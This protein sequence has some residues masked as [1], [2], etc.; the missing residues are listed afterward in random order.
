MIQ[1]I[2]QN[3]TGIKI[4]PIIH[5]AKVVTELWIHSSKS[6]IVRKNGLIEVISRCIALNNTDVRHKL[7]LVSKYI[8][9][10]ELSKDDYSALYCALVN[11]SQKVLNE[12]VKISDIGEISDEE[13]Q[14]NIKI[15][16][17]TI[18]LAIEEHSERIKRMEK[19]GEK[20]E[21]VSSTLQKTTQELDSIKGMLDKQVSI[22]SSKQDEIENL[23]YKLIIKKKK[24]KTAAMRL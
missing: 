24:I 10:D 7:R 19:M 20:L 21:E 5:P 23:N 18:H 17:T 16:S 9:E 6:T 2:K 22:N 1:F 13:K 15:A 4:S 12:V 8:N 3:Y 14:E 11:R